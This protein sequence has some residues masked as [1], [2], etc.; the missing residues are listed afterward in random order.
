MRTF[1]LIALS[2]AALPALAQ[3]G[4]QRC[5]AMTDSGARLACYDALADAALK[6]PPVPPQPPVPAAA[7][8]RPAQPVVAAAAVA[9]PAPARSG[10]AA[11]GLPE[12]KRPDAVASVDS[13]LS[14]SFAGWGPNS[15]IKLDNGQTWLVID[16]T[17]VALP[18]KARKVSV[19]RG[20]LG[21]YYLDIE[22]LNTSPRVRRVD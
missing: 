12:S 18:P 17:S 14:P 16:G 10:E 9:A 19:K 5:R 7:V 22:G 13:M 21:S 11:F 3:D 6:T 20:M 1:T 8:A 2:I 4:L 15:R